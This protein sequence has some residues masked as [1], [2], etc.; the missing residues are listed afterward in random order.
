MSFD[1]EKLSGF[2]DGE[3]SADETRQV[4]LALE[5]D[6]S[7]AI[8]LEQLMAAEKFAQQEFD[9]MLS[10]PVPLSLAAT[11]RNAPEGG[12]GLRASN[13]N[14]PPPNRNSLSWWTAVAAMLALVVG[15]A[16]G[17]VTASNTQIQVA[18]A[19]GWLSDIAD[20][21]RVYATQ[22]RHL[23]EV[24]ASEADHIESWLTNTV[25]A[26]VVIPDLSGHG[27]EFRGGR[28]LVASGKPV[29]QLMFTG[30]QGEV[31]ALCLIANAEPDVAV[32]ARQVGGLEMVTWGGDQANYVVVANPGIADLEAIARTAAG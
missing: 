32:N 22:V 8:E 23:V 16:G 6:P 13:A 20:Y 7:L 21:H 26:N 12:S 29:A 1:R 4:E 19:P 30:G 25:G 27:L 9:A 24:P 10:E 31:V 11:V 14:I 18:T 5:N 15:A 2:L 3:L 17:Y 28:L